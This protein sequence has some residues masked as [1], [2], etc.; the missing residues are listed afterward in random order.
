M[1]GSAMNVKTE[2][3]P[4]AKAPRRPGAAGAASASTAS[5]AGKTAPNRAAEPRPYLTNSG[6]DAYM[7]E[8]TEAPSKCGRNDCPNT[9]AKAG[10]NE[11]FR[12]KE[13]GNYSFEWKKVYFPAGPACWLCGPVCNT[14]AFVGNPAA[15]IDK[16]NEDP[17][18]AEVF[19]A[20]VR[21][22]QHRAFFYSS[23]VYR[24]QSHFTRVSKRKRGLTA[25]EFEEHFKQ[26]H[27]VEGFKL[28]LVDNPD[29]P[30]SKMQVVLVNETGR[31]GDVGVLV[32]YGVSRSTSEDECRLIAGDQLVASQG[33]DC[34]AEMVRPSGQE[35]A[36]YKRCRLQNISYDNCLPKATAA[37]NCDDQ[38]KA[39]EE[40]LADAGDDLDQVSPEQEPPA[41]FGYWTKLTKGRWGFVAT[42]VECKDYEDD[43]NDDDDD[44][45]T[46]FGGAPSNVPLK[47]GE[48]FE[49]VL[50][51]K[52]KAIN[53]TTIASGLNSLG[54]KRARLKGRRDQFSAST[55]QTEL[56]AA[57]LITK[58]LD[59]AAYAEDLAKPELLHTLPKD[60]FESKMTALVSTGMVLPV[61]LAVEI[62]N[63]AAS[64][65]GLE[66][67]SGGSDDYATF[68]KIV[69]PSR[70]PPADGEDPPAS[71]EGE[72][73]FDWRD[74]C[75]FQIPGDAASKVVRFESATF[76]YLFC[77]LL[78]SWST[79]RS[80]EQCIQLCQQVDQILINSVAEDADEE[81]QLSVNSAV[82]CLRA[83]QY[84]MDPDPLNFR[85]A[86]DFDAVTAAEP[87]S[88]SQW[89]GL[90]YLFNERMCETTTFASNVTS[91]KRTKVTH[92]LSVDK[93][94]AATKVLTGY[95][96]AVAVMPQLEDVARTMATLRKSSREGA[97]K[98][99]E[100]KMLA[101][102]E[103][104][105]AKVQSIA[106]AWKS[107]ATESAAIGS[108]TEELKN[109]QRFLTIAQDSGCFRISAKV[110]AAK[111]A[112]LEIGRLM[113]IEVSK[114]G[115]GNTIST[116]QPADL[117][118][119]DARESFI[120]KV[121][122][123]LRVADLE[124][125]FPVPVRTATVD[126]LK[127]V[128]EQMVGN[129]DHLNSD[130]VGLVGH[131]IQ[132]LHPSSPERRDWN[133]AHR[134]L[135][136]VAD[137]RTDFRK[138][139]ASGQDSAA[140]ASMDSDGSALKGLYS[141]RK[142]IEAQFRQLAASFRQDALIR[143]LQDSIERTI[144]ADAASRYE[145]CKVAATALWTTPIDDRDENKRTLDQSYAGTFD[146]SDWHETLVGESS[147]QAVYKHAAKTLLTLNPTSFKTRAT[148]AQRAFEQAREQREA[149]DT[150]ADVQWEASLETKI[151]KAFTTS[152]EATILGV[153]ATVKDKNQLQRK[154]RAERNSGN[155]HK[156]NSYENAR[157]WIKKHVE[158][159][160][161][162][163]P[164]Q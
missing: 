42:V 71:P 41:K 93:I 9:L 18:F 27:E 70:V 86:S 6:V 132:I 156:P 159:A 13:W 155:A 102:L 122:E 19:V 44:A 145:A 163:A 116:I 25:A 11:E 61:S 17:S 143:E 90:R 35:D 48:N 112:C 80:T 101:Y 113:S 33:K 43:K 46:V 111:E 24:N 139:V 21:S 94:L 29:D 135:G 57:G 55:N 74:P 115:F 10:D 161:N 26:S 12:C 117:M 88:E 75:G 77:P 127:G 8:L 110:T 31:L 59:L 32:E 73:G 123:I 52:I 100:T 131:V 78:R 72:A 50:N 148:E 84:V 83:A 56:D 36:Q 51:D 2:G 20:A 133:A 144:V 69:L 106:A 136:T 104:L 66:L 63:R 34:F 150:Q 157:P 95:A 129:L 5:P 108:T 121:N 97:T 39:D 7:D 68:F 130:T 109:T 103:A 164:L 92:P 15:V 138:Y 119:T 60:A 67:T 91:I 146:G 38:T 1:G 98:E 81:I 49:S 4:S 147:F 85:F 22:S 151:K 64:A 87:I 96:D 152:K 149:F 76:S 79:T 142:A 154:C 107:N 126:L 3:P 16:C 40:G 58:R 53:L 99:L 162:L 47:L 137:A 37:P 125:P 105:A 28:S 134:L 158:D 23:D 65:L 118:V 114:E 54:H 120:V 124:N 14:F 82:E 30:T 62:S 160:I 153:M 128:F 45:A 141:A 140:R 89:K